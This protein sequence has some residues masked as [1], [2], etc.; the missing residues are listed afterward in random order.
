MPQQR[1]KE[2][3]TSRRQEKGYNHRRPPLGF[4][5]NDGHLVPAD[6]YDQVVAMLDMVEQGESYETNCFERIG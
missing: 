4:E 3:I 5:T 6:N 1:T 2:G